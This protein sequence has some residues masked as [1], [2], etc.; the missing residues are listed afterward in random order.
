M[1]F[2]DIKSNKDRLIIDLRNMGLEGM[3]LLGHYS[4]K[5]TKKK[6][7]SHQHKDMLEICYLET[8]KQYYQVGNKN[9]LLKGGDILI[10]PPN[11]PHGTN[12]YPEEKGDLF[13]M[14]LKIPN[15]KT[16]LLQLSNNESHLLV[17]KLLQIKNKHFKGNFEMK[18]QLLA[19]FKYYNQKNEIF[20]RIEI[21]NSI[22]SFLLNVINSGE[23]S[24]SKI[25]SPDIKYIC[26]YIKKNIHKELYICGLSNCVNLSESRFKHKFKEEIGIPPN[27][28][29]IKQKIE[30]AKELL[31]RN[32]NITQIAYDLNFS[33]SSY[34]A[35]VFKKYIG[36]SPSTYRKNNQN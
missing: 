20:K 3:I 17:N 13:W 19:I 16:R 36:I 2:V 18:K 21:S 9:Y 24:N 7:K 15:K 28:F 32:T 27:E 6:L 31:K 11:I 8:G 34:F 23:K 10:T 35:T 30:K 29:I 33:T 4:Y 26:D 5:E 12:S 14:L 1:N 22:L 25:T